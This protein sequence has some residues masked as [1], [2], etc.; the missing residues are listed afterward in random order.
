MPYTV[1]MSK[2]CPPD[3]PWAVIKDSDGKVMGCHVT[4][5]DANKQVGAIYANEKAR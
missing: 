4:Q 3:K 1:K 2:G 5:D